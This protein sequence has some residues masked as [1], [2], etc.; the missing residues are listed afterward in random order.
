MCIHTQISSVCT[1]NKLFWYVK[2][3]F[4]IT[5][6]CCPSRTDQSRSL[7][8]LVVCRWVICVGMWRQLFKSYCFCFPLFHVLLPNSISI[9]TS[10][11]GDWSV[12]N[13]QHTKQSLPRYLLVWILTS[14]STA[15]LCLF[16]F[17]LP[18][19]DWYVL[20][21]GFREIVFLSFFYIHSPVL[22]E[23]AKHYHTVDVIVL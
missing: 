23:N 17:I 5:F 9:V 16:S 3:V 1:Q 20:G 4:G 21:V 8:P 6:I 15:L 2:Y 19:G 12:K 18:W 10:P 11:V 14:C 7:Q 22:T 13:E